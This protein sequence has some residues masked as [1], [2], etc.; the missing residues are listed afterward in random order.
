MTKSHMYTTDNIVFQ[1]KINKRCDIPVQII[2]TPF[3]SIGM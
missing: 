1:L 2:L 3:N